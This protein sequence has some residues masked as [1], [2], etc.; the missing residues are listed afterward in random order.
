MT[1]PKINSKIFK[2]AVGLS[3][4]VFLVSLMVFI[5]FEPVVMNAATDTAVVTATVTKEVT[6]SAPADTTFS[7]S[8]PGVSGNPGA[9]VTAS[10]TWR[11][12]T[13]DSLGFN[14]TLASSQTNA[15]FQNGTYYFSDYGTPPTPTFGWTGPGSGVAS[16]GFSIATATAT[17]TSTAFLNN[18]A[19][20]GLGTNT[21]GCWA[22]FT[23]TTPI[24]VVH[25]TTL[26]TS[27]GENEVV[28]FR[29]ES[30]GKILQE[31]S[32]AATITATASIN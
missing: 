30:N 18:G 26:T 8:I 22:G 24:T 9:P 28:N 1:E 16:F 6:I 19:A 27:A 25:R 5:I 15:L 17:D 29:A 32:Y 20:C 11:V 21:G 7:A 13:N 23:S 14:M 31:G 10:L 12:I 4:I 3:V 2:K